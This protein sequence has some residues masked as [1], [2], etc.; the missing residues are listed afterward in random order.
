MA[1]DSC[2]D[3]MCTGHIVSGPPL[4]G[5]CE[6][7]GKPRWWLPPNPVKHPLMFVIDGLFEGTFDQ[8]ENSFGGCGFYEIQDVDTK[9]AIVQEWCEDE[10]SRQRVPAWSP[11]VISAV[12]VV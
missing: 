8:F 2:P 4:F 6:T 10:A 9:L 12:V 11:T 3:K 7:C 1:R 5:H